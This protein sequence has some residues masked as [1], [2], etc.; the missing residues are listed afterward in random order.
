LR[1]LL[2]CTRKAEAAAEE[3]AAAAAAAAAASSQ[4]RPKCL[5]KKT[6]HQ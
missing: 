2:K 5:A 1:A 3:A 6:T 4:H